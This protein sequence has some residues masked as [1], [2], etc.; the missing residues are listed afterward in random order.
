MSDIK[1]IKIITD[2]FDDE[3][4]LLIEE[5]PDS[6]AIIVIWF[7]LLCLAG[8]QNNSGVFVM[9][10]KIPYTEKML[11]TIFR[12]KESTVHLA[13]QVFEQFGMIQIV[14]GAITIPNWGKHQ[15][16]DKLE[17]KSE[18]MKN[19]MQNYR[20]KQKEIACKT[21]SKSN[22]KANVS[23]A[24]ID[25]KDIE[26]SK[27]NKDIKEEIT[28]S[29]D[30]VRDSE[31]ESPVLNA[32][33]SLSDVGI[34]PVKKIVSGTNRQKM[35]KARVSQYSLNDVIAAIS[36]IRK[37]SFLCGGSKTGWMID[38]DWFIRPNNFIKVLEGKYT[39]RNV[40][41]NND[42]EEVKKSDTDGLEDF[43]K[44]FE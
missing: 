37:S 34:N 40:S 41:E 3:K 43:L 18:Y 16:M 6:D 11:A 10:D 23:L 25:N 22:C 26:D 21:N 5:M 7:K 29:K 9:N 12:R 4:I 24:D 27:D 8:K 31:I 19:Y 14:N 38:F 35:L 33:N 42:S 30:N 13:L 2:I 32:W 39:D 1:W 28:L 44:K 36:N 17:K 15:T 20:E